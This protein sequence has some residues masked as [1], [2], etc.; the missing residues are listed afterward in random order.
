[1]LARGKPRLCS[2]HTFSRGS[3]AFQVAPLEYET[4]IAARRLLKSRS[5][6]ELNSTDGSD[7]VVLALATSGDLVASLSWSRRTRMGTF[8]ENT[9]QNDVK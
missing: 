2:L 4:E 1:M 8:E 3:L 9:S 7:Q 5:Q 6:V